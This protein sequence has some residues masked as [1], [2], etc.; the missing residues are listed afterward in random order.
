MEPALHYLGKRNVEEPRRRGS[1]A[2]GRAAA[3]EIVRR[4]GGL[5]A[6][7]PALS[8]VTSG[9]WPSGR[10]ATIHDHIIA[11]SHFHLR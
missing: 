9:R 11:L 2:V 6:L 1:E 4:A 3:V 5:A 8:I 7:R 10:P